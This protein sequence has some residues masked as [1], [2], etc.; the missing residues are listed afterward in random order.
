MIQPIIATLAV[1]FSL[2]R[3]TNFTL[4]YIH[5]CHLSC[6]TFAARS[7]AQADAVFAFQLRNPVHNG[8]ALLMAET[9]RRLLEEGNGRYRNPVLLLHPLGGWTKPD[10]VPLH[11]RMD[12]HA[13][14][15]GGPG[16]PPFESCLLVAPHRRP[17]HGPHSGD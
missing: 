11:V 1:A 17:V 12:Q 7:G 9:R 4:S 5:F 8:H 3:N 16:W 10:D 15:L 6:P 13:A 2:S 14:C